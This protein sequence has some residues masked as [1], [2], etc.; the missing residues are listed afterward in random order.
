M[1]LD[2]DSEISSF[3]ETKTPV[4]L[5]RA[6]ANRMSDLASQENLDLGLTVHGAQC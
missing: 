1:F 6:R 5:G 4:R 2:I 3:T